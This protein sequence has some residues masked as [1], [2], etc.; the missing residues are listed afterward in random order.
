MAW[1]QL[2]KGSCRIKVRRKGKL[3]HQKIANLPLNDQPELQIFP[4]N[5]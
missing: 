4:F 2:A 1:I 5:A 3:R